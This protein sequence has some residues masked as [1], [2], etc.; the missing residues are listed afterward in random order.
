MQTR[1]AKPG[2]NLDEKPTGGVMIEGRTLLVVL[3]MMVGV[4]LR[5]LH[6]GQVKG[7]V[8]FSVCI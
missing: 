8:S 7:R 2:D 5:D 6:E 1:A 3:G 4:S